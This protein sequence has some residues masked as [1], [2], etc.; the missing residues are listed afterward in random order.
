MPQWGI[1]TAHR[2]PTQGGVAA[3]QEQDGQRLER[4]GRGIC[5]CKD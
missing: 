5:D 3:T 2:R 4:V 1:P